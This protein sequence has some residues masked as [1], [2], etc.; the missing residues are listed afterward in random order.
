MRSL[1]SLSRD[2]INIK[3]MSIN[4]IAAVASNGVIGNEQALPWYVPEDLQYFKQQTRGT[5][6]VMGRKTFESIM[7][8]IHKPLPDRENIVVTT[9][10]D[11]AVPDGVLIAPSPAA[12]LAMATKDIFV[13]GGA[14]L[15]EALL[16]QADT[17]YITEI[18]K[19]YEGDTFFPQMPSSF[20]EVGR[21]QRDGFS[22]VVYKKVNDS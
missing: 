7:Q 15:Y 1:W 19:A 8:R 17:V 18:E 9:Q 14:R 4:I 3:N 22:F 20:H 2:D 11:Y 6:V 21:D 5:S 10:Q 16:P 12:A 13:I